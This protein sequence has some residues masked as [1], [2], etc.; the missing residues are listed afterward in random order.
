MNLTTHSEV[1]KINRTIYE[2]RKE[3]KKKKK[4]LGEK[5][6]TESNN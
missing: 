2:L 1:N 4:A 5:K 3:V 6:E